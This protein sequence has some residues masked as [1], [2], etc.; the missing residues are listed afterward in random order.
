METKPEP[1]PELTPEESARLDKL[2]EITPE[3]IERAKS[4]WELDAPP[5]WR[6]LLS[7]TDEDDGG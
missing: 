3:D 7:A 6:G 2:A 4:A 5:E 1:A